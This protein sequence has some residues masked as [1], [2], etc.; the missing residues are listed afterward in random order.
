MRGVRGYGDP[1]PVTL[2]TGKSVFHQPSGAG[3]AALRGKPEK[4]H[5]R[6]QWRRPTYRWSA[7]VSLNNRPHT[8]GPAP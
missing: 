8:D 6:T 7:T 1:H 5:R 3:G 4:S 2:P